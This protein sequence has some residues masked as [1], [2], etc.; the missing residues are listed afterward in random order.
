MPET[1]ILSF[2]QE[3]CIAKCK[4]Q[5]TLPLMEAAHQQTFKQQPLIDFLEIGKN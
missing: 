5:A 4:K 2:Q 1:R 3:Q